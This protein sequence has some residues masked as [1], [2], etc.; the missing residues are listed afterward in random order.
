LGVVAVS[1]LLKLAE[2]CEL[3]IMDMVKLFGW[4]GPACI[5]ADAREA[6]GYPRS[7]GGGSFADLARALRA[8]AS[9]SQSASPHNGDAP[10]T[11]AIEVGC[12]GKDN[13]L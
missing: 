5:K 8:R 9:L 11:T 6:L 10:I 3:P 12:G 13:E 2:R 4:T 7:E 1:A